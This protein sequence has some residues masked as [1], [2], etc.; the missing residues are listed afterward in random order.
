MD[1]YKL[2]D[3]LAARLA[4]EPETV[5]PVLAAKMHEAV[6]GQ[7]QEW[8]QQVIPQ[9][10][11]HHQAVT[12]ANNAA[13]EQFYSSWPQLKP[14]E[15]QVLTMGKMYREMNP[16]A[17]PEDAT[18]NIGRM[19]CAALGLP[20]EP[21]RQGSSQ[22]PVQRPVQQQGFQPGAVRSSNAGVAPP[23]DNFYIQ[24]A[25]DMLRDDAG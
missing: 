23:A 22:P 20:L 3:D 19:V 6:M 14:Y 16:Q 12:Q 25:E 17:K 5:L 4:T 8:T 1:Y 21:A 15:K 9:F 10:L 18:L 13:K 11:A 24:E 7:V 2:P